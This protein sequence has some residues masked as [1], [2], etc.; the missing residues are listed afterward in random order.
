MRNPV[1]S[2]AR[3]FRQLLAFAGVAL[4][5]AACIQ[6]PVRVEVTEGAVERLAAAQTFALAPVESPP[7]PA[8]TK[9]IESTLR[10]ELA[11]RGLRDVP[12][13]EAEVKIA[14]RTN[15]EPRERIASVP[16][17]EGGDF[18][19][20]QAYTEKTIEID[21]LDAKTGD[22]LWQGVGQIDVVSESSQPQ[23]AAKV[24]HEVLARFPREP[25]D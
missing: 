18:G 12:L 17:A 3:R 7:P 24:V 1:A 11:D 21:V 25:V 4:L 2:A 20:L 10:S 16:N 8:V 5:W 6:A 23:A 22:V 9:R 15:R 19:T 13:G 14:Y